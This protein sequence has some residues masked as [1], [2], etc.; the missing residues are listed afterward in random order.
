MGRGPH[1]P[2]F[3]E[4]CAKILIIPSSKTENKR[5]KSKLKSLSLTANGLCK[6]LLLY[7]IKYFHSA[8]YC[9][10]HFLFRDVQ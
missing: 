7:N 6:E 1:S 5:M 10:P 8:C 4:Y 3:E 2:P 9:S